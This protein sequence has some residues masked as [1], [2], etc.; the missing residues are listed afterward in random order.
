MAITIKP[1]IQEMA[2]M[3]WLK[4][5]KISNQTESVYTLYFPKPTCV[6]SYFVKRKSSR[7]PW[8]HTANWSNPTKF[9]Y[10]LNLT[11][12]IFIEIAI[13]DNPLYNTLQLRYKVP[14][15]ILTEMSICKIVYGVLK[16]AYKSL[17]LEKI[18]ITSIK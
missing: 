13:L 2:L 3:P 8:S 5:N 16:V 1:I 12:G 9:A 11:I 7:L 17:Y 14:L 15:F 4:V 6:F 18:V 10:V